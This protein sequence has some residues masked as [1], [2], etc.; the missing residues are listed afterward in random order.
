MINIFL[1]GILFTRHPT[2][3]LALLL[4]SAADDARGWPHLQYDYYF[5]SQHIG[6]SI[7]KTLT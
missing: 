4:M 5:L 7:I 3:V 6:L 1:Y 2:S